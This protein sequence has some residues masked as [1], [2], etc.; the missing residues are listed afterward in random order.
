MAEQLNLFPELQPTPIS[1]EVPDE[2][3]RSFQIITGLT[4]LPQQEENQ[5]PFTNLP[6]DR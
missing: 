1:S 3:A 4:Q 6:T 5:T 2:I